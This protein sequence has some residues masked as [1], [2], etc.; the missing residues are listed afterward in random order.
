[1]KKNGT[2]EQRV[3]RTANVTI[4]LGILF[5]LLHLLALSGLPAV[6]QHGYGLF[7]LAISLGFFGLGY[8]IRYGSYAAFYLATGG[9][10]AL[11]M[12]FAARYAIT[13]AP[14]MLLRS[15]VAAWAFVSL[16]RVIADIQT[17]RQNAAFP[18]PMSRYGTF[19]LQRRAQNREN[20]GERGK[21]T[22]P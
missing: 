18:L 6:A 8:G 7:G 13:G 15:G 20:T 3:G 16:Y 22:H 12:Y 1:V 11:S 4:F 19:F 21:V 14:A 2:P 5:T 10:A 17:L 9:F